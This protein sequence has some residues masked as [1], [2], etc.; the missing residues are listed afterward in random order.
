MNSIDS[1]KLLVGMIVPRPIGWI[2]TISDKGISNLAPY[3]FFN[4]FQ[5]N[6]PILGFSPAMSRDG[7]LKDSLLNVKQT[8]CFVHNLVTTANAEAMNMT[9]EAFEYGVSEFEKVGLTALPSS[10]V[11]APRVKESPINIECKLNQIIVLGDKP[12]NGQI[13]LGEVVAIHI[14]D[15]SILGSDG[16]IDSA[17]L[18]T[19]A[20][21]GKS[22]Y[23]K[24]G[25]VFSLERKQ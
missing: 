15:E 10:I 18:V 25:E 14:N 23:Q 13:V 5:N 4:M 16:L 7:R 21:L 11:S 6:P 20:R 24:Q 8:K 9:S 12:G 19:V 2:S 1:Y 3:S 22:E 17:K